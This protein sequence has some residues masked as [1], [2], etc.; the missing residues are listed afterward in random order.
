MKSHLTRLGMVASLG[1]AAACVFGTD[2][3]AGA[4]TETDRATVLSDLGGAALVEDF[5]SSAH[6]PITTGVLNSATNLP[7]I[8]IVPGTILPGVTYSTPI[9]SGDFF[10]IDAGGGFPGGFLDTFTGPNALTVQFATAQ[11]AFG[12]DTNSLMGS[13]FHITI[14]FSGGGSFSDTLSIPNTAALTGF[15]FISSMADI[16]S[17]VI[18]NP[19]A[20]NFGFAVDNFTYAFSSVSPVPEPTSLALLGIALAGFSAIRLPRKTVSHSSAARL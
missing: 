7:S 9:G 2:A 11:T 17:A 8:G 19:A 10:N 1:F 14:N 3:Q 12:F 20:G 16:T 13:S 18:V 4:I 15:G 5:T 6:F